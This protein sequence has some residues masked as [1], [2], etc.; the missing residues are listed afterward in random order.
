MDD[1]KRSCCWKLFYLL[2]F[3]L[4]LTIC[5][6]IQIIHPVEEFNLYFFMWM[7]P[8]LILMGVAGVAG[9]GIIFFMCFLVIDWLIPEIKHLC[10]IPQENKSEYDTTQEPPPSYSAVDIQVPLATSHETT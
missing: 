5:T 10:C 3:V 4:W 8:L 7:L 9:I 2:I 1:R 6:I